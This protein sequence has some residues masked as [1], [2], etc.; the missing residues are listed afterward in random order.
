MVIQGQESSCLSHAPA[1]ASYFCENRFSLCNILWPPAV[2]LLGFCLISSSECL[3]MHIDPCYLKVLTLCSDTHSTRVG[4]HCL[5]GIPEVTCLPSPAVQHGLHTGSV[6]AVYT[7]EGISGLGWVV[8][9]WVRLSYDP[10]GHTSEE[11]G[12]HFKALFLA[13]LKD[14]R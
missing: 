4:S 3:K 14:W 7:P 5:I 2:P 11:D 8:S 9:F 13:S 6:C 12:G 1:P 10:S